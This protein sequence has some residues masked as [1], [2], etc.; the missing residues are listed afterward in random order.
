MKIQLFQ[1]QRT[2]TYR[3]WTHNYDHDHRLLLQIDTLFGAKALY[4]MDMPLLLPFEVV[5]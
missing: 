1:Q 3:T 5:L 2:L 4:S